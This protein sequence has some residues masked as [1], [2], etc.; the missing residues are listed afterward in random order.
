[1]LMDENGS[2]P[3]A[4]TAYLEEL[5]QAVRKPGQARLRMAAGDA[6]DSVLR[7]CDEDW[8]DWKA[9]NGSEPLALTVYLEE[10]RHLDRLSR[11]EEGRLAVAV[12]KAGEA[13]LRMAAGDA[14]DS[15]LRLCDEG[16]KAEERL[17]KAHLPLVIGIAK[18][19][20]RR[21]KGVGISL[22]DL[23]LAGNEGLFEAIRRYNPG[24]I[25]RYNA[26]RPPRLATY[27]WSW[28]RNKMASEIRLYRWRMRIPERAY[29]AVLKIM[30][31][32]G[33]LPQQFAREPSQEEVGAEVG[34]AADA[35]TS[36][37]VRWGGSDVFSLD[38][39]IGEDGGP[40][41]R[42]P[43]SILVTHTV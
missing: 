13:R 25:G 28:I 40:P 32:Y 30:R 34:M 37:L 9:E 38:R 12:R 16:R 4:L 20:L 18:D 43:W 8:E 2:E 1:M 14:D 17:A 41:L 22:E 39:Y 31:A 6:D 29:R 33:D 24:A 19:M 27:A 42:T 5:R 23:L 36:T 35:V 26:G 11:S 10:L 3:V 21:N 15:V 7:L